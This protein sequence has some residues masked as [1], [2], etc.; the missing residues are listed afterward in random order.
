MPPP[1]EI[2]KFCAENQLNSLLEPVSTYLSVS[3]KGVNI[4]SLI[5]KKAKLTQ[6][7]DGVY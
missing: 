2:G 7:L 6:K 4:D 3:A 1:A 5:D